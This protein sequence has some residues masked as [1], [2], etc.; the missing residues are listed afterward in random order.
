MNKSDLI[1]VVLSTYSEPISLIEKSVNSILN[2]SYEN[3]ELILINDNPSRDDLHKLLQEFADYD[4]RIIYVRNEQNSGLV[5][6]LNR[7]IQVS[8]G[9]YVARMDADDISLPDRFKKQL[10]YLHAHDLDMIGSY[11]DFIDENDKIIKSNIRFPLSNKNVRRFIKWG[12]CLCHPSWMLKRNVYEELNSYRM[13][14]Y[15]ED[16]DFIIRALQHGFRLGNV[17]EILL[18]YRLREDGISISSEAKQYVLRSFIAHRM[19]REIG[20]SEIDQYVKSDIFEHEC[21]LYNQFKTKWQLFRDG[22][23]LH[24]FTMLLNKYFWILGFEK[25]TRILRARA[26]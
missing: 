4:H 11:I 10:D 14:P 13:V 21:S 17:P 15:C 1:S 2:Q 8:S 25:I 19:S 6:S 12:S 23:K 7:G 18:K 3:I 20:L 24:F 26:S 5:N 16:Y 9:D 22:E